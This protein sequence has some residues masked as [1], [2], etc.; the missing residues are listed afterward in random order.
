MKSATLAGDDRGAD[1]ASPARAR[2]AGH[3][4]QQLLLAARRRFA[5]NGYDATTVRDI[6]TD[7]GV[8]VALINRYFESKEGLFEAC[9][10][11]A[12]EELAR[13]GDAEVTIEELARTIVDQLAHG[14]AI[15][16]A[17]RLQM[18]LLVRTSGDQRAETIRRAIL[19]R[20]AEGMAAAAGWRPDLDNGD[21]LVLRAQIALATALGIAL[22]RSS[23]DLEPL[24]SASE[25]ELFE[26]IREVLAALLSDGP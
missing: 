11:R 13:S 2:D 6:A 18:L 4:K 9:I 14:S 25:G 17:A 22:L 7:A 21:R 8:N 15:D 12:G 23:S 26:P 5:F 24:S 19:R 16:G 10:T 1:N 20:Y 3:T